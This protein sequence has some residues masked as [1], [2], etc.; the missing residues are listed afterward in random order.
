MLVHDALQEQSGGI[1]QK[2]KVV[3]YSGFEAA[4]LET[5]ICFFKFLGKHNSPQRIGKLI[6]FGGTM[7]LTRSCGAMLVVIGLCRLSI[8]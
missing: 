7:L 3:S 6:P 4:A 2:Q 5:Y 8:N 1:D